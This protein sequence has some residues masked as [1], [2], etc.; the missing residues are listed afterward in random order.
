MELR[1]TR[2]GNVRFEEED[3]RHWELSLFGFDSAGEIIRHAE[4]DFAA[5]RADKR[6]R[7]GLTDANLSMETAKVNLTDPSIRPIL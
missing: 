3:P 2:F 5:Y 6:S 1:N 4:V 7:M